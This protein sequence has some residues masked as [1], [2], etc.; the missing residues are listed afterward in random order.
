M[1]RDPTSFF[2]DQPLIGI[3]ACPRND[4]HTEHD[5]FFHKDGNGLVTRTTFTCRTCGAIDT[6]QAG[7]TPDE[8]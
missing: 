5:V 4:A 2:G 7:S 1:E 8:N 6:W 3:G